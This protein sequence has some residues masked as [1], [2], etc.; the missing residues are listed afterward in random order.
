MLYFRQ[1]LLMLVSLYTV[2]VVLNTL[3]VEDYGTYSVVGGIVGLCSF[4]STSMASATQRFFSFALGKNNE[5]LLNSTFSVNLVIYVGIGIIALALL[6]IGGYWFVTTHL[7]IPEARLDAAIILFHY[8]VMTFFFTVMTAPFISIIIAHEDM[9]Y[10]A[11][12]S[13]LEGILKLAAVFLLTRLSWDKLELYGL[14]TLIVAVLIAIMY[15]SVCIRKYREC[16]FKKFFW[17]LDLMKEIFSFTGWSLLGQLT[18]VARYQAVTIL[19]NQFFNPTV[20]AARAIAIIISSKVNIFSNNFNVGLSPS[21]IKNYA[22]KNENEL[23]LLLFNGSKLTF[24]LMWIFVLPLL[25]EMETILTIWLEVL[26]DSVVLFSKLAL[27]ESLIFSLSMPI[28][29]AARATGRVKGYELIL[30]TMQLLIFVLAFIALKL[31]QPAYSVFVIAITVNILMFIARLII[32]SDLI[33]LPKGRFLMEVCA[34]MACIVAMSSGFAFYIKQAQ[35]ESLLYSV[36]NVLIC[37]SVSLICMYYIGLD[38]KFRKSVLDYLS[39]K[40]LST[41]RG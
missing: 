35:H 10:F 15:G 21:I 8:S 36:F 37:I 29:T 33:G 30:G 7:N 16:Q 6:E 14:L 19:L 41:K 5:K 40:F 1:I 20:A 31:G 12:I 3:G 32:V 38:K 25:V 9:H 22:S 13:I 11:F 17:D 2:R 24:F 34:P 28:A 23:F 39:N 27:I 26:P 4:L 18:T